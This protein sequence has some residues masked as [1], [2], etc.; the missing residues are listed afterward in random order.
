MQIPPV[1]LDTLRH[2]KYYQRIAI[3][4][5]AIFTEL[6]PARHNQTG[7]KGSI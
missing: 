4:E 5:L 3:A 7:T 6:T 1:G 2:L